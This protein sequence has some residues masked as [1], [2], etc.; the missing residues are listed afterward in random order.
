MLAN[1]QPKDAADVIEHVLR[2]TSSRP[3]GLSEFLRLQAATERAAGNDDLAM[4]TLIR[5][6]QLAKQSRSI[7]W[8]LRSTLDLAQLLKDR[9]DFSSARSL[10]KPIYD[11]FAEGQATGDLRAASELL[12]NLHEIGEGISEAL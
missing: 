11:Q 4:N 9:G 5:S 8:A 1:G 3:W 6:A 7:A 12:S 2:T 10:L